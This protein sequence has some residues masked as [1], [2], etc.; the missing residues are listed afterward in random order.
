MCTMEYK[1]DFIINSNQ[2]TQAVDINIT[3]TEHF[4]QPEVDT[5]SNQK[6]RPSPTWSRD[7]PTKK[8]PTRDFT[9]LVKNIPHTH[10]TL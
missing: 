7:Q 5:I 2:K 10:K 3:I 9:Y 6:K 1:I 4:H 8:R